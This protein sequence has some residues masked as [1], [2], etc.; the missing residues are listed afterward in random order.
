MNIDFD[1]TFD[2][3]NNFYLTCSV[4]RIS[5]IIAHYESLKMSIGIIG[6]IVECGLFKGTSFVNFASFRNILA[7]HNKKMIGF[8]IFDKFPD[9]TSVEDELV[10]KSFINQA[11]ET[12]ITTEELNRILV[13]KCICNTE[14]IK[15]NILKTI[16]K[17]IK[18]N[19]SI[20]ISLLNIDTDTYDSTKTI[21]M[22]MYPKISK[23]GVLLLDDYNIHPGE[24]KAVNEYFSNID[25][26]IKKFEFRDSPYYIIKK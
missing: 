16:P 2:F 19:P 10:R 26:E 22:Y 25:V 14:L 12:S 8:D 21:L 6:D 11:G 24:T 3:E 17:Y 7:M 18:N 13:K 9:A 20:K 5:K 4:N 23:G 1:K 15:G